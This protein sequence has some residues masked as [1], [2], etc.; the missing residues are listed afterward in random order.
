[1]TVG[2]DERTLVF[3]V[4]AVQFVNILDFMMVM[5]LGPDFARDL[6]I[7]MAHLGVIGGSYSAAAAVAGIIAS[8]FLERFDRRKALAV[9][10]V[11]LSAATAA[12]GLATGFGSLVAARVLAGAFGGPATALALAIIADLVP[13]ERRGK[14][15]GA[16]AGAFAVAS[17]L[18]VPAGLELSRVGGWQTPFFAVATLGLVVA[19]TAIWLLPPITAHIEAARR[20]LGPTWGD[21]VRRPAV[22]GS[23][24][25]TALAL[26]GAFSVI[27]NFS[28]YFQFNLGYPRR[29]MGSLYLVGGIVSFFTTRLSGRAVDRLGVPAVS[30]AGAAL[31]IVM[32]G[33]GYLG[34]C[35]WLSA[36]L[37]FSG[38]MFAMGVRTV[39]FNTLMSMV[40]GPSERARF[41][42]LQSSVQHLSA[43]VGAF[44][45]AQVLGE[46]VGGRLTNFPVVVGL[47]IACTAAMPWA[48][49]ATVRRLPARSLG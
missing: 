3:L 14:A 25:V 42:A 41:M 22:H 2:R 35:P 46:G 27:P 8:L 44:I 20:D 18:G 45:A 15:L 28:A 40:P 13:Q 1:M 17:V 19:G 26:V 33:G 7:P 48:V 37:A 4:S 9:A 38:F 47:A 21:L 10:M 16:M 23:F 34:D 49:A 43:S 30:A 11:G 29:D 39:A 31:V 24:L 12:G 32:L 5:P 6:G 36:P